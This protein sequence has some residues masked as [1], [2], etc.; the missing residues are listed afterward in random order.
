M[1]NP[2]LMLVFMTC[3]V[4]GDGECNEVSSCTGYS[5][6]N[7]SLDWSH[8]SSQMQSLP[9][10]INEKEA[11]LKNLSIIYGSHPGVVHECRMGLASV[12]YQLS[13]I[14][15]SRN[16]LQTSHNLN[17]LA[18]AMLWDTTRTHLN[19]LQAPVWGFDW[20]GQFMQDYLGLAA[21]L[22]RHEDG[23]LPEPFRG[24]PESF[25]PERIAIASVCDYGPEHKLHG[26]D[27][28][29]KWNRDQYASKHGY[30]SV[31]K[32][33]ND[34]APGRHP[35]WA[36]LALTRTLLLP[37]SYEFVMWM[38]CDALFIDQSRK[39]E[40][41]LG[42]YP[43]KDIYISE[44]GRGLS[45]GNWVVRNS[46]YAFHVLSSV[47]ENPYFDEWDLRD[48]FGLLWTLLRPSI[49][50]DLDAASPLGYPSQVALI[51]QRLLNAYPWALCRPSHHCFED[52]KDFIVSFITLG[53]LSREMAFHLLNNYSNRN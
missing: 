4:P 9:S 43:G 32:S 36:S 51:P 39:I 37:G 23:G 6:K 52:G 19:C 20:L 2:H 24:D 49:N 18:M 11:I 53:S 21:R 1:S 34:D 44:D 3:F 5:R 22:R 17:Q 41:I 31:F 27:S 13:Q 25:S 30:I 47:L 33:V 38:D 40:E 29:S 15:L 46:G 10:N 35:V 26:I 48:Q 28:I 14:A 42:M 16:R 8:F 12:F 50:S 7:S 45:G